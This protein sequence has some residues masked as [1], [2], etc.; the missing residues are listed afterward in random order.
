VA[1]VPGPR[2][3][4]RG[5]RPAGDYLAAVLTP[6]GQHLD[7]SAMVLIAN[8][9]SD[10]RWAQLL[11]DRESAATMVALTAILTALVALVREP[12]RPSPSRSLR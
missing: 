5:L 4:G 2:C 10:R 1:P 6:L 3:G 9:A 12:G 8:A 7:T 11:L